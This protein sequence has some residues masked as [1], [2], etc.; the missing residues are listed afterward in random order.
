MWLIVGS[1]AIQAVVA[2]IITL[3][4]FHFN[5]KGNGELEFS[6][7]E[8]CMGC[9][10]KT[11]PQQVRIFTII[12]LFMILYLFIICWLPSC[13][14]DPE[15]GD[16]KQGKDPVTG[17]D[18]PC[19]TYLAMLD[20]H[21]GAGWKALRK[22]IEQFEDDCRGS[23]FCP[24]V[25]EC[26]VPL[27]CPKDKSK[28]GQCTVPLQCPC[29]QWVFQAQTMSGALKSQSSSSLIIISCQLLLGFAAAAKLKPPAWLWDP[30]PP[31]E[32][33][34]KKFLRAMGP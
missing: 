10:C 9:L 1:Y 25:D 17:E 31:K 21:L 34:L 16:P 5:S 3:C 14:R 19:Y 30:V 15:T 26:L 32:G 7:C 18:L 27:A 28:G 4:F 13:P 8:K 12:G 20:P 23:F 22:T 29:T 33:F 11:L 6:I 2:L 24:T